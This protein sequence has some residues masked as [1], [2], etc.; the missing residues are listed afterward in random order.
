MKFKVGDKVRIKNECV[1]YNNYDSLFFDEDMEKFK[2]RELTIKT[3]NLLSNDYELIEDDKYYYNDAMLE[4]FKFKVGDEVVIASS[5]CKNYIGKRGIIREIRKFGRIIVEII[6]E[7]TMVDTDNACLMLLKDYE[8]LNKKIE[9]MTSN[10]IKNKLLA[11]ESDEL[12]ISGKIKLEGV[13]KE[14]D[15]LKLYKERKE[16]LINEKYTKLKNKIREED[17]IQKILLDTEN[18]INVLLDID[19][20]NKITV[21]T[22]GFKCTK[23]TQKKLQEL[24]IE[25]NKKITELN[26]TIATLE[27][28]FELTEDYDERIKILQTTQS[29]RCLLEG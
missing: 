14:M 8:E 10:S 25:K 7:Y 16:K 3:V 21:W 24:D 13:E 19:E 28:L 6:D 26:D 5:I 4:P 11:I 2:N 18:Q 22:D 20:K 27:S 17:E 12:K 29:I 9:T 23:E 15:I 1:G